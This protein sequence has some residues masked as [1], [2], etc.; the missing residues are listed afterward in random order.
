VKVLLEN[1]D[2][3]RGLVSTAVPEIGAARPLCPCGCDR[4]LDNAVITATH[5]RDP[6]LAARLDAVAGRVLKA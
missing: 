5:M 2:R 6:A 4:A 1:A 3:A